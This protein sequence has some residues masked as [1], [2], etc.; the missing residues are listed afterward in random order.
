MSLSKQ[1]RLANNII[2][3]FYEKTGNDLLAL[4][5][6][7]IIEAVADFRIGDSDDDYYSVLR[8]LMVLKETS[9]KNVPREYDSSQSSE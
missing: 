4:D 2:I 5:R 9:P 1:R 7:G 6:Q 8:E 3:T